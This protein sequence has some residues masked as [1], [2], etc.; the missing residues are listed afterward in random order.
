[1]SSD[2]FQR[3]MVRFADVRDRIRDADVLLFRR[4]PAFYQKAIAIAGRSEYSHAAMTAW[5]DDELMVLEV[6]E[7][8]GGRAV[9]LESQS[10]LYAGQYDVFSTNPGDRWQFDRAGAVRYMRKLAGKPYGRRNLFRVAMLHIPFVRLF[11]KPNTNDKS[12]GSAPF[13]SNAVSAAL[14]VGGGIDPVMLLADTITEPGDL[15]RSPFLQYAFTLE[16]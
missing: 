7:G 8:Y 15:S 3:Q 9:T 2:T 11:V 16:G 1:M 5:W 13:C 14:R 6:A 12:N 10:K 4:G